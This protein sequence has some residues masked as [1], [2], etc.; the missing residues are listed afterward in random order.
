ME[1]MNQKKY[2]NSILIEGNYS[3][4][5]LTNLLFLCEQCLYKAIEKEDFNLKKNKKM[6]KNIK[7]LSAFFESS[8]DVFS[9]L[10]IQNNEEKVIIHN[11]EYEDDEPISVPTF[12]DVDLSQ[13]TAAT[14]EDIR[15][16]FREDRVE[17]PVCSKISDDVIKKNKE[18]D[19]KYNE[20]N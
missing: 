7:N 8:V 3:F 15:K 1:K 18:V 11:I 5:Y 19:D 14:V 2:K 13:A 9:K 20:E 17:F 10:S 12:E 6:L 4:N 16:A